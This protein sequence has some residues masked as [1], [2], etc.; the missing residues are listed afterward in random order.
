MLFLSWIVLGCSCSFA[1]V[2]YAHM[3]FWCAVFQ[4]FSSPADFWQQANL[5]VDD[6]TSITKLQLSSIFSQEFL[7]PFEKLDDMFALEIQ[8]R[9]R[10][11]LSSSFVTCKSHMV[12]FVGLSTSI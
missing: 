4:Y 12:R 7:T 1:V 8:V 5:S 2:L 11:S 10:R 6:W 9:V 3:V